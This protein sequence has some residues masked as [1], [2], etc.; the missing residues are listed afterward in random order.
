MLH[1]FLVNVHFEPVSMIATSIIIIW[2]AIWIPNRILV[3]QTFS[4]LLEEYRTVHMGVAVKKVWDFYVNGCGGHRK[5]IREEVMKDAFRKKIVKYYSRDY[6]KSEAR[7]DTINDWQD[8]LHYYRRT[9]SQF[10]QHIANLRFGRIVK[11]R[12]NRIRKSLGKSAFDIIG[13]IFPIEIMALPLIISGNLPPTISKPL[14]N[15]HK[16]YID[17]EKWKTYD[18]EKQKFIKK[19]N[20]KIKKYN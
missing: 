16:L 11:L 8:S 10:Y 7:S 2:V 20:Y 6:Y 15:L 13:V 19:Y 4:D 18:I 12:K 1:N 9:V 3:N 17:S 5:K 14:E